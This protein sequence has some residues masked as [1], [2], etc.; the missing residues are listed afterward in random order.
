[1]NSVL[2]LYDLIECYQSLNHDRNSSFP[3]VEEDP[4]WGSKWPNIGIG[5]FFQKQETNIL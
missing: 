3:L 5:H 2:V 1:M 4:L